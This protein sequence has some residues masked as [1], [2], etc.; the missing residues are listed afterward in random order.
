MPTRAMG[1]TSTTASKMI[2]RASLVRVA[3]LFHLTNL[4]E[5]AAAIACTG[6][7]VG[8]AK[9]VCVRKIR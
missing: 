7:G 9:K 5:S 4:D 2:G 6:A 1:T 3:G 8:P